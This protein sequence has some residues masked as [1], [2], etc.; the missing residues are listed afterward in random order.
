MSRGESAWRGIYE[1][2][3]HAILMMK[4]R[5]NEA[6]NEKDIAAS[7]G[8]SRTPVREALLRLAD[9]GLVEIVP[10]LGTFVARIPVTALPDAMLIRK[11]I[12]SMTVRLAAE[13]ATRS[14]SLSLAVIVEKQREA[15][16]A[17][18]YRSFHAADEEFHSRI[19]DIAGYPA[20]WVHVTQIKI[21]VDRYR[22]LTLPLPGRMPAVI[23]E[24]EAVLQ[25]IIAGDAMKSAALME[26]HLDA[27]LPAL[28]EAGDVNSE[29]FVNKQLCSP[30]RSAQVQNHS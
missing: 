30:L 29:Y 12:E 9:E 13:K 22:Q 15:A 27:V 23:A 20:L 25:A 3:R 16:E 7:H 10:K 17:G 5:P 11:A 26:R 2:L 1:P 28:F 24:H 6:L 21:Q 4:L 18:D 19:A 14:Q 8:V